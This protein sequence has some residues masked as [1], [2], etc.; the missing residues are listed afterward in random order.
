M[1]RLVDE[2][3]ATHV[4]RL[5]QQITAFLTLTLFVAALP[6][7][8]RYPHLLLPLAASVGVGIGL[9]WRRARELSREIEIDK[10]YKQQALPDC[11]FADRTYVGHAMDFAQY[12]SAFD[13]EHTRHGRLTHEQEDELHARLVRE[14]MQ[15]FFLP[16]ES[17]V[18]HVFVGGASGTGKTE[19]YLSVILGSTIKRGA[20]CLIF[21]AKGDEGLITSVYGMADEFHRA[22]DV[23]FINF[24]KPEYSH[25]Y[26]PLLYGSVRE[27]VSTTMKLF[28]KKGEQY[29]RDY[30]RA[31]MTAALLAIRAQPTKPAFNFSDLAIIFSDF[32]AFYRLYEGMPSDHPERPIVLSFLKGFEATDREGNTFIDKSQ[33]AKVLR[34]LANKMLDFSH[35]EYR[36]VLNDYSPDIELKSAILAN[37]IIIV[38]IPALSDKEG[39]ELF[40]KLFIGD[41]ARAVGQIQQERRKATFPF[42]AFLD[43]YPSFADESHTELWQQARSANVSLWPAVQGRG[44]LSKVGQSFMENLAGNCSHHIY[45]DMRDPDSREFAV[46]LAGSTIRRYHSESTSES[47][48]YGHSNAAIGAV[49]QENRGTGVSRS[50]REQREDLL[51]ADDFAMEPGNA[52]LIAKRGT[53]RLSTPMVEFKHGRPRLEDIKLARFEKHNVVGLNLMR[54]LARGGIDT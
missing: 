39:V 43:E 1:T 7:S 27:M 40:G 16:D 53:Y 12:R 28:D 23:L 49:R 34:G 47:S 14:H 42:I 33:Y 44:F 8:A 31:A 36:H 6:V 45:F 17:N 5:H 52:I 32:D 50:I 25:T 4:A 30:A 35:S 41:F 38:V 22:E 21:D 20:G 2:S 29:F 13:Q 3:R 18:R 11:S 19:L 51:Q 10:K 54:Q 46:K 37:K 9:L 26:N 15:P 48:G 24:N